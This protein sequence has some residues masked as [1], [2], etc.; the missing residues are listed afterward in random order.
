MTPLEISNLRLYNQ[1]VETTGF[2]N[3][4]QLVAWMG[5]I[6]SQDYA[7]AKWAIG[8]RI[9]Q[10]TNAKI[11]SAFNEGEIIRTHVLRPTW[12]FI[13]AEDIYWMLELTAPKIKSSMKSRN[14]SWNLL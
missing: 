1:Q 12:H 7:M 10:A 11:E 14:S 5:A 2:T 3:P 6:Q 9:V 13:C 8:K 4:A